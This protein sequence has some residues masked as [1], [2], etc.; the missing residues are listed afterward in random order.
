MRN[1]I[2]LS[3]ALV[4]L[5]SGC[6]ISNNPTGSSIEGTWVGRAWLNNQ[7]S[8]LATAEFTPGILKVEY[9]GSQYEAIWRKVGPDKIDITSIEFD[10]TL[11]GLYKIQNGTL[12]LA[13]K[14][15]ERPTSSQLSRETGPVF[16]SENYTPKGVESPFA[17]LMR[18]FF[19]EDSIR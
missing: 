19:I 15:E 9:Q 12:Y 11:L 17:Q 5:S 14:E 13:L 2:P 10:L 16:I 7:S 6:P 18:F 1:I 4:F 3:L 8:T